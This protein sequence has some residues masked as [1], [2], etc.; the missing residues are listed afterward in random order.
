MEHPRSARDNPRHQCHMVVEATIT[1]TRTS[2]R[3]EMIGK[4]LVI[5]VA[6]VTIEVDTVEAGE[7]TTAVGRGGSPG[8]GEGCRGGRGS[9]GGDCGRR[10]YNNLRSYQWRR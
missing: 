3:L 2:H 6:I 10:G 9:G 4:G 5:G 1:K 7:G 8:G